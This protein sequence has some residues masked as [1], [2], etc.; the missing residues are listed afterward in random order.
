MI[1]V[2]RIVCILLV[3]TLLAGT[4]HYSAAKDN[5]VKEN[6]NL[7]EPKIEKISDKE[8]KDY[9]KYDIIIATND[10]LQS[11]EGSKKIKYYSIEK[12]M[13]KQTK[14]Q[15]KSLGKLYF[16]TYQFNKIDKIIPDFESII[17]IALINDEEVSRYVIDYN[18][19][20]N[21]RVILEYYS[22]GME[23]MTI[24]N[25]LTCE[26]VIVNNRYEKVSYDG[27][28]LSGTSLELKEEQLEKINNLIDEGSIEELMLMEGIVVQ[29]EKDGS[30]IVKLVPTEEFKSNEHGFGTLS[31]PTN[32]TNATPLTTSFPTYTNKLIASK[33]VVSSAL[34]YYKKT[35][36]NVYAKVKQKRTA[37]VEVKFDYKTFAINTTLSVIGIY[38]GAGSTVVSQMCY[39]AGIVYGVSRHGA[40]H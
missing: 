5:V 31:V 8:Y 30:L 13:Q 7:N 37:Y 38:L 36:C 20:N 32:K 11:T 23:N 40:K 3:F 26:I 22:N 28:Y 1:K 17:E 24:Y 25:K 21:E 15:E 9:L 39:Y 29:K 18:T 10:P 16:E 35:D 12:I 6:N 14:L 19:T 27:D 33:T 2:K 34:Q 4:V